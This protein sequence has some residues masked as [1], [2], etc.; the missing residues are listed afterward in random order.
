MHLVPGGLA[1]RSKASR[2]RG[3]ILSSQVPEFYS[4]LSRWLRLWPQEGWG[5]FRHR[6][7]ITQSVRSVCSGLCASSWD[8]HSIPGSSWSSATKKPCW[9]VPGASQ[10]PP[11]DITWESAFF[12]SCLPQASPHSTLAQRMFLRYRLNQLISSKHGR[13]IFSDLK[14]VSKCRWRSLR[15][16]IIT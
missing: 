10:G 11:S 9:Q 7:L 6:L 1:S 12:I 3:S 16:G 4:Q 8:S 2:C 13:S 15:H 5:R 14:R